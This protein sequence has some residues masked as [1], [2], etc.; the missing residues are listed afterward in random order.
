MDPCADNH[1]L[2]TRQLSLLEGTAPLKEQIR[3]ATARVKQLECM[4]TLDYAKYQ[5]ET[6]VLKGTIDEIR[7]ENMNSSILKTSIDIISDETQ[8]KLEEAKTE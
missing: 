7:I 8:A 2:F 1:L 4:N 3:A 6:A 5:E